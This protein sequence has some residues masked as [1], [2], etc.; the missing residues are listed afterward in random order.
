MLCFCGRLLPFYDSEL[1]LCSRLSEALFLMLLTAHLHL[2]VFL[3]FGS[4]EQAVSFSLIPEGYQ[5][6]TNV[7]LLLYTNSVVY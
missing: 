2:H 3:F 1:Q 4:V 6:T 7:V 5:V